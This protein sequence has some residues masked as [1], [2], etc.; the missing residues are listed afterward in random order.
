MEYETESY[1]FFSLSKN[2]SVLD[3]DQK[4]SFHSEMRI[5]ICQWLNKNWNE[6][7]GYNKKNISIGFFMPSEKD[8]YLE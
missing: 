3:T 7:Y 5:V 4:R 1:F 6:T 2:V 8:R